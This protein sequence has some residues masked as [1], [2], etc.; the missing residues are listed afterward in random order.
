MW[1]LNTLLNVQWVK[2]KSQ[3]KLDGINENENSAYEMQ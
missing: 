2:K 1:K 3:G